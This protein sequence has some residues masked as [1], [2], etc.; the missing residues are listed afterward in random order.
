MKFAAKVVETIPSFVHLQ[1][2]IAVVPQ[3]IGFVE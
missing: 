2:Y 1:R 3:A